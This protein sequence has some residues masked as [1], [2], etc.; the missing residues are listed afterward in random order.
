MP[1]DSPAAVA[2]GEEYVVVLPAVERR[3]EVDEVNRLILDV[4]AQDLQI[5]AV[6]SWFFS[7]TRP[8]TNRAVAA[9]PPSA[10]TIS[11]TPFCPDAARR[12]SITRCLHAGN[13]AAFESRADHHS[14]GRRDSLPRQRPPVRRGQ[15]SST[16]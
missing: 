2:L 9:S 5:V 6:K 1:D 15:G 11:G 12:V 7:T 4:L 8:R 10:A 13:F 14:Y 16:G 3:I